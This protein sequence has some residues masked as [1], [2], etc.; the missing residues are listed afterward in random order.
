MFLK[1]E[2]PVATSWLSTLLSV[3]VEAVWP[4]SSEGSHSVVGKSSPGR[5]P[6]AIGGASTL[7]SV[8]D[9]S[10]GRIEEQVEEVQAKRSLL[11]WK[12]ALKEGVQACSGGGQHWSI[13]VWFFKKGLITMEW[14][15][16]A[17]GVDDVSNGLGCTC[18]ER[19]RE[20]ISF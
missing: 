12:Y 7:E 10:W 9:P 4:V 3:A 2:F 20:N 16:M 14:L 17:V 18:L 8:L 1:S 11:K 19:E 5:S 13:Y 15:S 6:C